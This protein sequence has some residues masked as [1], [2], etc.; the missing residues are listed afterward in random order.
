MGKK[1]N[2]LCET[3]LDLAAEIIVDTEDE[4]FFEVN[5]GKSKDFPGGPVCEFM[6]KDV[7][8][9]C[10]RS[11]K[12]SVNADILRTILVILGTLEVYNYTKGCI[13]CVLM[14]GNGS[15]F[16][17]TFLDYIYNPLHKWCVMIG[18]PYRTALCQVGDSPR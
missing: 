1:E 12:G 2:P 16:G 13:P 3:G 8:C 5:A 6:G 14:D 4:D 15:R 17:L 9:F 18:V 11:K 7:P 10:Q